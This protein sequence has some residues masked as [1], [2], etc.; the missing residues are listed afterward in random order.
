MSDDD[1]VT[2]E[3]TA[4]KSGCSLLALLRKS[5]LDAGMF[6]T[7]RRLRVS[8]VACHKGMNVV[9]VSIPSS[10]NP[11]IV[12]RTKNPKFCNAPLKFSLAIRCLGILTQEFI[13][14]TRIPYESSIFQSCDA[15]TEAVPFE[16]WA[17][18]G[19]FQKLF[20]RNQEAVNSCPR[21]AGLR[22]NPFAHH[23]W[24]ELTLSFRS[25][26]SMHACS[27]YKAS[28]SDLGRG[29][30]HS[31]ARRPPRRPDPSSRIHHWRE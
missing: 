6:H 4:C 15:T 8:D 16:I 26:F 9:S 13:P 19:V 3:Q 17:C 23:L 14:A 20:C 22:W 31:P 7:T 27:Y 18:L 29:Y 1:I 28:D 5:S 12:S 2:Y 30:R 24:R 21:R 25:M 10:S 11:E